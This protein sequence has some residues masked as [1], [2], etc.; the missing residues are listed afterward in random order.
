MLLQAEFYINLFKFSAYH[1]SVFYIYSNDSWY[2]DIY[3]CTLQAKNVSK[4]I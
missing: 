3:L 1:I 2:S 4:R